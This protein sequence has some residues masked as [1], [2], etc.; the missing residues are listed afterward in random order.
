MVDALRE[1]RRAEFARAPRRGAL[2]AVLTGVVLVAGCQWIFFHLPA[3]VI[4]F[5]RAAFRLRDLGG[6]VLFNDYLGVYFLAFGVGLGGLLGAV[7]R[8][9]EERLLE[10]LLAKPVPAPVFLAA[11]TWPALVHAAAV[12]VGVSLTCAAAAAT[13]PGSSVT[14]AGALGAG[15]ALT[16]LALLELAALGV[17][18]VRVRDGATATLVALLLAL[19]PLMP[20]AVFLYRPDVFVGRDAL[21]SAIVAANLVWHDAALVW[22]GPAALVL[23]LAASALLVRAGG[24]ALTRAGV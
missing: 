3:Q 1:Y 2:V 7:V 20:T 18:F 21:A 10:L 6:V 11:R 12:G 14:P 19:L 24:R 17:W 4:G 16:S 9:R 8:P 23:E 5:M 22:I 13:F 15:L